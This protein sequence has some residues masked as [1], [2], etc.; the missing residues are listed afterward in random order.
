MRRI[1]CAL[2]LAC[3][4]FAATATGAHA[5]AALPSPGDKV[6]GH[7]VLAGATVLLPP[8][9]WVIGGTAREPSTAIDGNAVLSVA[10]LQVDMQGVSSVVLAQR[11]ADLLSR[12][13][14]LSAE[15]DA[16][17]A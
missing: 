15:C 5:Q 14:E 8:G 13:P 12:R 16:R 10:L 1:L 9:A 4:A 7:I 3:G 17:I 11:N 6:T 2:L